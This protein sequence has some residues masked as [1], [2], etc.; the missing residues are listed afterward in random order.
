MRISG[1]LKIT[2]E[3]LMSHLQRIFGRD[4][5][6]RMMVRLARRAT[7]VVGRGRAAVRT[8]WRSAQAALNVARQNE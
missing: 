2:K 4:W 8:S 3:S 1:S 7:V 5:P 6:T